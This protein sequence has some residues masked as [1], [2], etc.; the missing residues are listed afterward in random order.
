MCITYRHLPQSRVLMPSVVL[1]ATGAHGSS[2]EYVC[3]MHSMTSASRSHQHLMV[4]SGHFRMGVLQLHG[5]AYN[6]AGAIP[7]LP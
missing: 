6:S 2:K 5:M 4:P 1:R 7:E 3:T